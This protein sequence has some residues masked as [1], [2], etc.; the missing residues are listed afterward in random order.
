MRNEI[1]HHA[2]SE[3]PVHKPRP[4]GSAFRAVF[5]DNQATLK[6]RH[7]HGVYSWAQGMTRRI[8][9]RIS[10]DMARKGVLL[11]TVKTAL[12]EQD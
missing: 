12:P 9:R 11:R 10:L 4:R 8:A 3:S 2:T 6:Q 5:K 1:Q 7:G